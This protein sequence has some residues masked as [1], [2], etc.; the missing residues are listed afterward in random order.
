M[1]SHLFRVCAT[2]A[3]FREKAENAKTT[4]DYLPADKQYLVSRGGTLL[5]TATNRLIHLISSTVPCLR[6]A[7]S[8]AYTDADED[9][10][11]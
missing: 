10:R 11:D 5:Q 1:I 8:L 9:A 2:D 6:R 7:Q 3:A 4:V